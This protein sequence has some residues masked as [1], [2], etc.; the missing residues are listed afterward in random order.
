MIT[1]KQFRRKPINTDPRGTP[2]LIQHGMHSLDVKPT[3]EEMAEIKKKSQSRPSSQ[4]KKVNE[5]YGLQD[6]SP[7]YNFNKDAY[8][9]EPGVGHAYQFGMAREIAELP[10]LYL[11]KNQINE[12]FKLE[13]QHISPSVDPSRSHSYHYYDQEENLLK[14]YGQTKKSLHPEIFRYTEDSNYL[15]RTLW[16]HFLGTGSDYEDD[17]IGGHNLKILDKALQSRQLPTKLTVFAGVKY[18]PGLEAAKNSYNR[19]YHPGYTSSS[20]EPGT[21]LEFASKIKRGR[22]KEDLFNDDP[23]D[24]HILKIH[25]PAGHPGEFIGTRSNFDNEKEFLIPRQ[26]T[27][28]IMPHPTIVRANRG[29]YGPRLGV[30]HIHL[31]DAHPVLNPNQ[32]E[33]PFGT[34]R[35]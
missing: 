14:E 23:G 5:N 18:N 17:R 7:T 30:D 3:P 13:N 34:R 8:N 19:L 15:N 24:R 9:A 21:G 10:D 25:L 28:Q 2:V 12:R 35:R 6:W 4:K 26:T 22:V 33:L 20:I 32:L 1:L 29:K 11:A 31:W 27:F 16:E